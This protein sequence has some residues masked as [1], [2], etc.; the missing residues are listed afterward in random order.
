MYL[1]LINIIPIIISNIIIR[2][3]AFTVVDDKNEMKMTKQ[4]WNEQEVEPQRQ[5]NEMGD[6]EGVE[7]IPD[8]FSLSLALSL[9]LD[10][11]NQ[12]KRIQM[13]RPVIPQNC[14]CPPTRCH[15]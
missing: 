8:D 3:L 14:A 11:V 2:D 13:S 12:T 1:E 15:H 5:K 4:G 6:G 7:G 9:W 10:V